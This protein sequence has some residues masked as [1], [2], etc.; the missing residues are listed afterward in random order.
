M[1]VFY[2]SEDFL[3]VI[4]GVKKKR[5]L[6]VDKIIEYMNNGSHVQL[7]GDKMP[8]EKIKPFKDEAFYELAEFFKIFGDP[9]RLRILTVLQPGNISVT[10]LAERINMSQSAVSH[11][12]RILKQARVVRVRREGKNSFYSLDDEHI[13][14]ILKL[15]ME[16]ILEA[17][18]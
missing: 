4:E 1:I 11:Q 6:A 17:E 16:H 13:D 12:L 3:Y 15:G 18:V 9:A 14:F 2:H 7:K 10:D 5:A 8:S